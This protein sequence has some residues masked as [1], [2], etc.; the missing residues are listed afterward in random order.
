MELVTGQ[1]F[2]IDAQENFADDKQT[3]E[4]Q[5]LSNLG[6]RS[7]DHAGDIAA[8]DNAVGDAFRQL[9]ARFAGR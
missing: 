6:F 4:Q 7:H 8:T 5:K 9:L 2:D 3:R 1:R